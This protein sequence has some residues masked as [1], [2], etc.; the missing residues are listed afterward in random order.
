MLAAAVDRVNADGLTVSLE[1]ISLEDVIRDAGVSRSA[2]Y[3]RWP[4]KDLFF[5]DLLKELATAT[6]PAEIGARASIG[7]VKSLVEK[8]LDWLR[9]PE[10][11]HR[12][13]VEL[14]RDAATHDFQFVYEST[15]WRT[16]LALHATFLSLAEGE[17]RDDV[18]AALAAA[19]RGFTDRIARSWEQLARLT[20]Y[21]LKPE[22]NATY[23]TLARLLTATSRGMVILARAT[24]DIAT[25]RILT[26]PFGTG[27]IT[28]W[29]LP[30]L[31]LGSVAFTFLEPDPTVEWN[32]ERSAAASQTLESLGAGMFDTGSSGS[33]GS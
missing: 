26:D 12:L 14:I 5:S 10:L 28:E 16:Y 8:H 1:H 30:A 17:L 20:G 7:M 3:R 31:G 33:H 13:V 29:S 32:E 23:E 27:E 15:E 24:P 21:R 18:Q 22:L 2:A 9:T 6:T 19:E 11:R 25:S 4:Y